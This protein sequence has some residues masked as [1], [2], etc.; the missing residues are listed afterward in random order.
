MKKLF[1]V[2]SLF[3][4][5]TLSS[6]VQAQ[7]G[8]DAVAYMEELL[9]SVEEFENET[10]AYLKSV[11]RGKSAR[12]IDKKRQKLISEIK[13]VRKTVNKFD[14]YENDESL[15]NALF[16]Y[17]D[18]NHSVLKEDYDKILDMEEIAEQSYDLMEAYMTAQ[19][20]AGQKMDQASEKLNQAQKVFAANNNINLIEGDL[21]KKSQKIKKASEVLSYYNDIFLIHFKCQIQE[22]YVL[23]A[24][25]RSDVSA[26]EQSKSALVSYVNENRMILDTFPGHDGDM[27]LVEATMLM[28]DFYEKEANEDFTE[29]TNFFIEKENFERVKKQFESLREKDITQKDVDQFNSAVN[30]FNE[31]VNKFNVVLDESNKE[32]NK[33]L[34]EWNKSVE[35]FFKNHSR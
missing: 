11:T 26:F 23:D 14:A 35:D 16:E 9:G 8:S 13:S 34:N 22:T 5:I 33:Q 2:F 21:D 18:I 12:R 24:L 30:N 20:L 6:N 25:T 17:L 4:A 29:V 10:W 19:E 32:R 27:A 3:C 7:D 1:V 15:K 28:M 31:A